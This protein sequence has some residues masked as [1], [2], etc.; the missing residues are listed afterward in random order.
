M[1][2]AI[3]TGSAGVIGSEAGKLLDGRGRARVG[4]EKDMRRHLFRQ[5]ASPD[6][7]T[8]QLQGTLKHFEHHPTDVRD[9]EAIGKIFER[10][11]SD[12]SLVV[13]NAPHTSPDRAARR[14]R[15]R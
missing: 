6:W 12:V 14:P 15:T 9:H 8:R 10:Y 4:I 2:V 13:H 3:V 5:D 7:N 11:G 1:S